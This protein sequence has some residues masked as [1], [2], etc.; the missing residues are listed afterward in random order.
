[1]P[2]TTT[3]QR[4]DYVATSGQTVFAYNFRVDLD[5]DFQVTQEGVLLALTTDFT[6]DGLTNPAG[7]NVTLVT[8]ADSGDEIIIQRIV[9]ITQLSDYILNEGFPSSRIELDYE[10]LT[11]ICQ[12]QQEQITR[13]EASAIAGTGAATSVAIWVDALTLKATG[14]LKHNDTIF[15]V[16][17]TIAQDGETHLLGQ[18]FVGGVPTQAGFNGN[19]FRGTFI[20]DGS[21]T[22]AFGTS[23]SQILKGASGDTSRLVL[24]NI[25]GGVQTQDLGQ[26]IFESGNLR[27]TA[28]N[29]PTGSDTITHAYTLQVLGPPSGGT[30]RYTLWTKGGNIFVEAPSNL[31]GN[32]GVGVSA[33][34]TSGSSVI[35]ISA[36]A[37]VPSTSPA[38]MIQIY[39]DN[40]LEGTTH[41][42]LALRTERAVDTDAWTRTHAL[43][44][45]LN[46]VEYRLGLDAV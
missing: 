46:G 35:G 1:M 20:S 8:G 43:R 31:N 18:L 7:G 11:M 6:V 9:P 22:A 14:L 33:F 15:T 3:S 41:A 45:W 23:F 38:G 37:T 21:S 42:T 13:A 30:N 28:G 36:D 24:V 40:T 5:T 26:T 34:G 25:D 29:G 32:I 17:P 27:I 4:E 10:K 12:Q 44:I 39:A 2:L 19:Q 16:G